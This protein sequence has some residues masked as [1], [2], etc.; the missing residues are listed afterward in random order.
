MNS[1][2]AIPCVFRDDAIRWG[3]LMARKTRLKWRVVKRGHI[4]L[5]SQTT[6]PIGTK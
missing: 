6:K 5:I 2:E 1:N 4:W 3:N